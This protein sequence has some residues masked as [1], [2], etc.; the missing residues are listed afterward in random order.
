MNHIKEQIEEV[1]SSSGSSLA[2]SLAASVANSK[3]NSP[4]K[5]L[6]EKE[7][8]EDEEVSTSEK[9]EVSVENS[10]VSYET[11]ASKQSKKYSHQNGNAVQL[12][13]GGEHS[14]PPPAPVHSYSQQN[15]HVKHALPNDNDDEVL[16]V[17]TPY[18]PCKED[19]ERDIDEGNSGHP[20]VRVTSSVETVASNATSGTESEKYYS[21]DSEP[22]MDEKLVASFANNPGTST[23]ALMQQTYLVNNGASQPKKSSSNNP[24]KKLSKDRV[25]PKTS[26]TMVSPSLNADVITQQTVERLNRDV[27]HILA[28]L[29]ILE[30]AYAASAE[31]AIRAPA[32]Q[33]Q[34]R[35][36]VFG[37]LSTQ[38]IAFIIMWPF[39]VQ[40]LIKLLR[41]WWR[42]RRNVIRSITHSTRL[43]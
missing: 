41:W 6:S 1:A 13:N 33:V 4:V 20:R 5:S 29:R 30:A 31:G 14:I 18:V 9:A 28:R 35:R 16:T 38:S 42:R 8:V 23:G 36:R 43:S 32:N 34:Q 11:K 24:P 39:V 15:G 25:S 22:E 21:G 12:S 26:S 27:D 2:N 37:N 17:S 19:L 10:S 7:D 40:F 3:E